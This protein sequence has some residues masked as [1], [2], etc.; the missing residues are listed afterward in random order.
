MRPG[1]ETAI[2]LDA[3]WKSCTTCLQNLRGATTSCIS[4][5]RCLGLGC[6]VYGSGFR[7][8]PCSNERI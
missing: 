7:V 2:R 3:V 4:S 5:L 1:L 8:N 6:R